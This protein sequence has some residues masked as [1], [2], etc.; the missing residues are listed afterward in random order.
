MSGA[1]VGSLTFNMPWFICGVLK[2]IY[3]LTLYFMFQASDPTTSASHCNAL[4][5]TATRCNTPRNTLVSD[6]THT[7]QS[8]LICPQHIE[9]E[10]MPKRREEGG[11]MGCEKS[12]VEER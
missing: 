8:P 9:D 7:P 1:P 5:H 12:G 2:I 4:Q 10:S 3:D 6:P 11:T